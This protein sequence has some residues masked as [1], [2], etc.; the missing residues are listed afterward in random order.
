MPRPQAKPEIAGVGDAS[1]A[2]A[3][4]A[5]AG[6]AHARANLA[7]RPEELTPEH[8][9][10]EMRVWL[11]QFRSYYSTS[12]FSTCTLEDQHAYFLQCLN[13]TLCFRVERH[14]GARMPIFGDAPSCIALLEVEFL[15]RYPLFARRLLYFK[16][17]QQSGQA[18]GYYLIACRRMHAQAD[19]HRIDG[20]HLLMFKYLSG[21]SDLSLIHI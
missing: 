11:A 21:I 4:H 13:P 15:H 17:E 9:P 3:A 16:Y 7:L 18:V 1:I 19:V 6:R 10:Q 20:D 2:G 12:G 14:V 8:T 5:P